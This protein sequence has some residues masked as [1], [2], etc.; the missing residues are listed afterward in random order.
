M[1]QNGPMELDTDEPR[2]F[3]S[4]PDRILLGCLGAEASLKF[5]KPKANQQSYGGIVVRPPPIFLFGLLSQIWLAW[6]VLALNQQTQPLSWP[7]TK[8]HR[9]ATHS[10]LRGDAGPPAALLLCP[11]KSHGVIPFC[12]AG[13]VGCRARKWSWSTICQFPVKWV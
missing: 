13:A 7:P 3:Y 4:P 8:R 9:L 10:G 11:A 1:Q 2:K 12:W 6:K 5:G